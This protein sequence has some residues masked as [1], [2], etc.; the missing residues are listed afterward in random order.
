MRMQ[1]TLLAAAALIAASSAPAQAD[2]VLATDADA[3]RIAHSGVAR[4]A[5][6][7][8]TAQL[9][10]YCARGG[11]KTPVFALLAPSAGSLDAAAPGSP[12]S[13]AA[14]TEPEELQPDEPASAAPEPDEADAA[15]EVT[16]LL[17]GPATEERDD[18]GDVRMVSETEEIEGLLKRYEN[19]VVLTADQGEMARY[20][21]RLGAWPMFGVEL[22]GARYGFDGGGAGAQVLEQALGRC[23]TG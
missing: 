11:L 12:E 19:H 1:G 2:W 13:D 7:D 22:G 4:I 10:M 23:L 6:T 14:D 9:L 17:V 16:M 8:A 21:I 18:N 15:E 5:S 20:F 3:E